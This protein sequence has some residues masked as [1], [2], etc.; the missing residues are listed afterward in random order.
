MTTTFSVTFGR[1]DKDDQPVLAEYMVDCES[2]T[3]AVMM[4]MFN[5]RLRKE[6]DWAIKSVKPMPKGN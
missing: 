5:V 3:T 6:D 4:A 2:E 1:Y